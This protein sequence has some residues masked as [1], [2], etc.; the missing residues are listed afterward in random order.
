MSGTDS[1][2]QH[3]RIEVAAAAPSIALIAWEAKSAESA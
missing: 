1:Q 3:R 2:Q